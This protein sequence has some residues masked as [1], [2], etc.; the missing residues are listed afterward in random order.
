[1]SA[2][3]HF[4]M[5]ASGR[6]LAGLIALVAALV[7]VAFGLGVAVGLL[8]PRGARLAETPQTLTASSGGFSPQAGAATPA[9]PPVPEPTSGAA[10]TAVAPPM[11]PADIAAATPPAVATASPVLETRGPNAV[12]TWAAAPKPTAATRAAATPKLKPT[13]TAVPR[14]W[15]QVA[16]LGRAE[17][18]EGVRQRVIALGF[19]AEQVLVLPGTGGKYRVRLGP[20]PDQES[21]GRVVARLQATG[22]PDA[23]ALKE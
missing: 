22:F 17:Q 1:V 10:V 9:A 2:E 19:R 6:Q 18:A 20:F 11:L 15:V 13:A 16:S 3:R 4:E 5:I 8:Q 14:P 12:A 7:L 21:A 23:F